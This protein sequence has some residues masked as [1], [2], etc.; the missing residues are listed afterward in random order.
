MRRADAPLQ[1][2]DRLVIPAGD[3]HWHFDP[4]GGPGGQHA[5]RAATRVELSF[6]VASSRSVPDD[7]RHRILEGLGNRA[8]DGIVT[9]VVDDSRSQWRNRQ[10]ARRR[11]ANIL[12]S[13][14]TP[15]PVRRPTRPSLAAKR[16]RIE[17]KR[18]RGELKRQRRKPF[19]DG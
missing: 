10:I 17:A 18:R 5:N 11:L 9:V 7:L 1:V 19:D 13:S 2:G 15:R 12:Q 6:D 16:R 8:R 4:S 3:L 14:L